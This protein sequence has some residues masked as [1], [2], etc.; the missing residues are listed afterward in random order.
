MT[1][2]YLVDSS[3]YGRCPLRVLEAFDSRA[4]LMDRM[5]A[6]M[7]EANDYDEGLNYLSS[8]THV[9]SSDLNVAVGKCLPA[10]RCKASDLR[11]GPGSADGLP[12]MRGFAAR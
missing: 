9:A 1:H 11:T 5:A 10:S 7:V 2:F 8:A 3:G 12:I 6:V 4:A